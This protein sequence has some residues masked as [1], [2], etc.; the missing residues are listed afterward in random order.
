[1]NE[2]TEQKVCLN[3]MNE[4]SRILLYASHFYL[5]L[6]CNKNYFPFYFFNYLMLMSCRKL[7]TKL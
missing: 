3:K 5:K 1:M 2:T 7:E 4:V 6:L